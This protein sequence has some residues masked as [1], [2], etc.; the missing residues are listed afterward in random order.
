MS[1]QVRIKY[2]VDCLN[3]SCWKDAWFRLHVNPPSSTVS[4]LSTTTF[5][6]APTGVIPA[7]NHLAIHPCFYTLLLPMVRPFPPQPH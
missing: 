4:A 5:R 3:T 2:K 6:G 1:F 7:R